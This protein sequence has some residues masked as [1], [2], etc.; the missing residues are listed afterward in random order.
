MP[1]RRAGYGV[2]HDHKQD[3]RSLVLY[4]GSM[5]QIALAQAFAWQDSLPGSGDDR[6]PA[7]RLF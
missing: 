4:A 2:V 5:Q 3:R 7:A 6:A 1:T